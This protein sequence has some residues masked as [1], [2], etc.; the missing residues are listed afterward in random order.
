[1]PDKP[2][3]KTLGRI[4]NTSFFRKLRMG[5]LARVIVT[6]EPFQPSVMS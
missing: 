6:D 1:M 4:H 5:I 2:K 3:Q